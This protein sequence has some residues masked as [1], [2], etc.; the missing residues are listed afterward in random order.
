MHK[1][2]IYIY[3]KHLFEFYETTAKYEYFFRTNI[4]VKCAELFIETRF[5]YKYL[6]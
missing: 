6:F 3:I 1:N 5:Y 2:H 4:Y